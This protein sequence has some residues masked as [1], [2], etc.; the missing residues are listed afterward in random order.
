V[1]KSK[2]NKTPCHMAGCF[3][4]FRYCLEAVSYFFP[5][6]TDVRKYDERKRR[7]RSDS[8][9]L[10]KRLTDISLEILIT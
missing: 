8:I 3:I 2:D 4:I 9:S 10:R 6:R 5:S 1:E 7:V